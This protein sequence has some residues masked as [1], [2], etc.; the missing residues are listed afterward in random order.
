[1][2]LIVDD[3]ATFLDR[4]REILNHDRRVFL[5]NNSRQAFRLAGD[6][7]FSVV[8]VDL[9]LRGEDSLKLIRDMRESFPGLPVIAINGSPRNA[10]VDLAR[11]MGAVEILHKPITPGWKSVVERVRATANRA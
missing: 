3:D 6:L 1:M 11:E 2:I 10:T 9:D 5:A 7:G 4:A 8:L